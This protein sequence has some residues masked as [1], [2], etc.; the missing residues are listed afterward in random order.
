[1]SVPDSDRPLT[2]CVVTCATQDTPVR[3]PV[4]KDAEMIMGM[5]GGPDRQEFLDKV[6]PLL[7]PPS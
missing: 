7:I 4:G 1:M 3:N 5:M 6:E 2:V